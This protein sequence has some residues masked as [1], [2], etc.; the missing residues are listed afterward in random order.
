MKKFSV[1]LLAVLI[2]GSAFLFSM[3]LA[4]RK[5]SEDN[6]LNNINN[7]DFQKDNEQNKIYIND[8]YGY[9]IEYP[10]DFK[11][12]ESYEKNSVIFFPGHF[13]EDKISSGFRIQINSSVI[14][15]GTNSNSRDNWGGYN[16]LQKYSIFPDS[17]ENRIFNG[18]KLNILVYETDKDSFG[19]GKFIP[20]LIYFGKN[21]FIYEITGTKL[22][23]DTTGFTES[24]ISQMKEYQKIFEEM[25][26]SFTFID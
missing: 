17:E 7:S 9:K 12:K 13:T 1:I 4:E 11:F 8:K 19:V 22:P 2:I 25:L 14:F 3:Y 16:S 15:A 6:S 5:D 23:N 21:N 26:N 24:E 18:Q 10:Q 20:E